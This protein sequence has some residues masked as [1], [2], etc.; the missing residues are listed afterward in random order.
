MGLFAPWLP[1]FNVTMSYSFTFRKRGSDAGG[2]AKWLN[3]AVAAC[4]DSHER[5][6]NWFCAK[7]MLEMQ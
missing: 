6:L 7:L 3:E 2:L 1:G 5:H 4:L